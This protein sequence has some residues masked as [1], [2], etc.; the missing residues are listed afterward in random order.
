MAIS[1][2]IF[3]T[4]T[5]ARVIRSINDWMAL[6]PSDCTAAETLAEIDALQQD[7]AGLGDP[8]VQATLDNVLRYLR[9]FALGD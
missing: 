9:G 3:C 4:E 8:Q 6:L 1:Q 2:D 7:I 5:Q